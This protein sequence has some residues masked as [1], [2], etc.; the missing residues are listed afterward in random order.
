MALALHNE[1][2]AKP[3]EAL[4]APLVISDGVML[5]SAP[6]APWIHVRLEL[7]AFHLHCALRNQF[8]VRSLSHLLRSEAVAFPKVALG[9]C[10]LQQSLHHSMFH[11]KF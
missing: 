1:V 7:V 4:S 10:W 3:Q 2:C 11:E 5:C 8:V 9:V 6:D